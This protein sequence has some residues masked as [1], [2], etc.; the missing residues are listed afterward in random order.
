VCSV[1]C[2]TTAFEKRFYITAFHTF[3]VWKVGVKLGLTEYNMLED[4]D[5]RYCGKYNALWNSATAVVGSVLL[6]DTASLVQAGTLV[7]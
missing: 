1:C 5:S 6:K 2:W 3:D 4:Y 7:G